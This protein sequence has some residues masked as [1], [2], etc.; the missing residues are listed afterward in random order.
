[1]LWKINRAIC[2]AT[3][4]LCAAVGASRA[5]PS[6]SLDPGD[7]T[8]KLFALSANANSLTDPDN[9]INREWT[10]ATAESL[11]ELL[12]IVPAQGYALIRSKAVS[13]DLKIPLGWH[14]IEDFERLAIFHPGRFVRIIIW[15]V[16]LDFEGV[17]DLEKFVAG[18]ATA[19]RN[20]YPAVQASSRTLADGQVLGVLH[21]VPPRKGDSEPRAILDLL[22]P[23]P[24]NPK[25]A[26]LMT[27]GAPMSRAQEFL[28]LMALIARDRKV[29]WKKDY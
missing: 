10:N 12:T 8:F 1:V 17:G 15:R 16:D 3:A 13:M 23:N 29:T 6:E 7:S 9:S 22:T 14:A 5:Q 21:N 28:P 25:R 27:F 26:V 24:Q 4:L 2:L 19:L 11:T 20:R 18:K